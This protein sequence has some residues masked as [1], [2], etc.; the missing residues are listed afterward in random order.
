MSAAKPIDEL[1]SDDLMR[2]PIWTWADDA[3]DV[4][5]ET[6][7]QP[8]S[9]RAIPQEGDYHVSCS[10]STRQG[11]LLHG[12][13]CVRDGFP[14][15]DPPTVLAK[16]GS[17]WS[18]CTPPHQRDRAAFS[19]H[20]GCAFNDIFPVRWKAS[21]PAAGDGPALEGTYQASTFETLPTAVCPFCGGLLRS[22][23]ARQCPQ[24]FRSWA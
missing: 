22:N 20:F 24:C 18:L 5:D 19:E 3:E 1:T 16:D 7:V 9:L 21:V 2:W 23:R 11:R 10:L 12:V 4:G 6:Y 13:L 14:E 15:P 17:A 8:T